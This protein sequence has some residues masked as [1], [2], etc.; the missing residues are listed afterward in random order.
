[1]P[2][3]IAT[4]PPYPW[5]LGEVADQTDVHLVGG[6]A[7]VEVD[8]DVAVVLKRKLEDAPDLPGVIRVVRG[9]PSDHRGTLLQRRHHVPIGLGCVGPPFLR[10]DA[11]LQIHGPGVVR[12]ELAQRLEAAKPDVGIDLDMGAHVSDAV[13]NALLQRLR[14][15]GVH[16][17]H[18]EPGLHRGH[19]LHV[20]AG[21]TR[22]RRATLDDAR[23]VEV[24]VGLDK[25]WRD[26]A[27]IGI[28]GVG[29]GSHLTLDGDDPAVGNSDVHG[30]CAGRGASNPRSANHEIQGHGQPPVVTVR[31]YRE[32]RQRER[33]GPCVSDLNG[34]IL[35]SRADRV[36]CDTLRTRERKREPAEHTS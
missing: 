6:G 29:I 34:R 18:R 32:S 35:R 14:G 20:V 23:L 12:G 24:D 27:A 25:A 1:M 9:R 4:R 5:T 17:L 7:D 33:Q 8:V 2:C 31:R 16:V 36:M 15:P 3:P 10:E 28:E 13:E 11:E 30:R 19:A 22:G 21:P 26:E